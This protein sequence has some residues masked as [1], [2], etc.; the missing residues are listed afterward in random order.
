MDASGGGIGIIYIL[1][2]SHKRLSK[3]GRTSTGTTAGRAAEYGKAHGYSWTVFTQLASLRIAE[4]ETNIHARFWTKR[5]ETETKAREIFRVRPAEAETVARSLILHPDGS[6]DAHREAIKGHVKRVRARLETQERFLLS[7]SGYSTMQYIEI[8][9]YPQYL[10][11]DALEL[12]NSI[13]E[14]LAIYEKMVERQKYAHDR[15]R[16]EAERWR[17]VYYEKCMAE[18][19]AKSWWGKTAEFWSAPRPTDIPPDMPMTKIECI[20][21]AP[22]HYASA[23][24]QREKRKREKQA[25]EE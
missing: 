25:K 19:K 18:W 20:Y 15:I 13:T 17:A 9:I 11:L 5:V 10:A 7:R 3:I 22:P 21:P 16:A 14:M 12:G 1:T 24:V 6:A 8:N 4:V 2:D 23:I